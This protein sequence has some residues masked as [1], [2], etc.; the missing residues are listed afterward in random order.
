MIGIRAWQGSV[1]TAAR[2]SMVARAGPSNIALKRRVLVPPTD[3]PRYHSNTP[4]S[5]SLP[6]PLAGTS[7]DN[8]AS[9]NTGLALG[10]DTLPENHSVGKVEPRLM[11][12]FTCTVPEC[13]TRSSHE[14]SKSSYEKGIVI[15]QCPGCKNRYDFVC[16]S[17]CEYAHAVSNA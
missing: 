4:S 13:G 12:Q 7:K 5:S 16:I 14:F 11:I 2:W 1:R 10:A 3:R 9:S 17:H 6:P 15:V 8:S